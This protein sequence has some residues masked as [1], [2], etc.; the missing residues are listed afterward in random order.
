VELGAGETL[1]IGGLMQ[2]SVRQQINKLPGLGD[3]PILGAL[4][5]SNGFKRGETELVIVVTPYLVQ[6]VDANSIKLPTDGYQSPDDVKRIFGFQQSDGKTGGDRPKP[7]EAPATQQSAPP[8]PKVG[9][10]AAAAPAL[11]GGELPATKG[12]KPN[13]DTQPGFN[14][15]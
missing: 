11:A 10:A 7:H 12:K 9:D 2:D 13:A 14:L 3:I 5:R 6:P 15:K 8:A 4:F 1:A